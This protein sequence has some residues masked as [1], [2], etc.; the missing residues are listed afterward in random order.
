MKILTPIMIILLW[1]T[2]PAGAQEDT[3]EQPSRDQLLGEILRDKEALFLKYQQEKDALAEGY[4]AAVTKLSDEQP[5]DYNRQKM[6]LEKEFKAEKKEL[7]QDYRRENLELEKKESRLRGRDTY[8]AESDV[9]QRLQSSS[10]LNAV[11]G[12]RSETR[13]GERDYLKRG[14]RSSSS[15]TAPQRH[16]VTGDKVKGMATKARDNFNKGTSRR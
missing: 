6:E 2:A 8:T 14:Q 13:R 3:A 10:H 16:N 7:L 9:R 5:A 11:I 12:T 1:F 15:L 4:D